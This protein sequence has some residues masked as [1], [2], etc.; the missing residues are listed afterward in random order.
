VLLS[1]GAATAFGAAND[2]LFVIQP[3]KPQDPKAPKEPPP[4]GYLEGPC[5]LA[6]AGGQLYVS[7][8]YHHAVDIFG[9]EY[10]TQIPNEDS[11]NGPCQLAVGPAGQLF[12][13]NFHSDIMR[14]LPSSF[15]AI[16]GPPPT[17]FGT[18]LEVDASHPTGV[19]FD[20]LTNRVYVDDRTYV[21]AYNLNGT[22]VM[23]GL[24]PLRIGVGE[25]KS[26]YGLATSSS[27]RIY[28]ADAGSNSIK[29]FDP[30][31][32]LVHPVSTVKGPGKGFASLRDSSVA[33]DPNNGVMYVVD[34]LQPVYTEEPEAVVDVFNSAGAFLGVLKYRVFDALPV[35]LAT[36]S[37]GVVYVTS[38]NTD[39][40]AIYGYAAGAQTNSSL[41]PSVGAI[42]KVGGGG[43]GV[44]RS[45]SPQMS[46]SSECSSDVLIGTRVALTATSS[47]NSTFSGWSGG[48]CSGDQATCV[49]TADDAVTVTA[50]FS[51]NSPA[52][53]Y[54]PEGPGA[55]TDTG[56]AGEAPQI[57]PRPP[58]RHRRS[59]SKHRRRHTLHRRDH[60]RR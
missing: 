47:D 14:F 53:G 52:P 15:P 22:P 33:V 55:Q 25:I 42:V 40:A 6:L 12:V 10:I 1:V 5:G 44:V 36:D 35:G 31:S 56:A 39:Q 19:A 9:G 27:G 43:A 30:A 21:A 8:Y 2:P 49:V 54:Q 37:A 34:N 57:Q 51:H 32:D 48:D 29:I 38:G 50:D 13:N 28:V 41:P 59:H 4:T 17:S 16:K 18:G 20:P 24:E 3:S 7:D 45:S 11:E 58:A 23:E 46:C 26:S 60:T